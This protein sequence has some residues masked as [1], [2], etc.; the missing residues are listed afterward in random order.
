MTYQHEIFRQIGYIQQTLSQNKKPIG[1]FIA[2]GCPLAV[3]VDQQCEYA[4]KL[5][6]D[7]PIIPDVAGLTEIILNKLKNDVTPSDCDR[8][9]K[10][11]IDDGIIEPNIEDILS[12]VRSLRQVAGKGA[13]REFTK[14]ELD[15][16]DKEICEIIS[17]I[18]DKPLLSLETPYH[19]LA[20][21]ARAIERDKPI[22]IFTT[23][24]DLLME[25]ALEEEGCP[26]FD[27]FI[28]SRK[29]FFDLRAV[30]EEVVLHARWARLWKIHGSI[31]WRLDENR[32]VI[33]SEK[34]DNNQSYLIYPSH[35]KYDQSRKMPYLAMLDRLKAFILS[36]SSALFLIGYSFSDDHI[37]D[38]IVQSLKSNPTAIIYAFM[39]GNLEQPQYNKAIQCAKSTSNLTLVAFDK[40]IIGRKLGTWNLKEIDLLST[41]PGDIVKHSKRKIDLDDKKID[42]DQF[43]FLLGDFKYFG[44]FLKEISA[45]KRYDHE[46]GVE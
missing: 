27:G 35:L 28:G 45:T 32:N 11:M 36:P 41:I 5:E 42:V 12:Q 39:Y 2:A 15:C 33:R 7:L 3:R 38:V 9:V 20:A 6:F 37:N 19:G 4:T 18:V 29:A 23:N 25:Q 30:E 10:Q 31:N 34:K 14:E 21:W 43:E 46:K 16:L 26:Y 24:Y 22:H 13:V 17:E 1:V 8:L 40:G 44:N